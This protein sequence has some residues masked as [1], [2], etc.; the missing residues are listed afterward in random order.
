[1]VLVLAAG[2]AG[3]CGCHCAHP[4]AISGSEQTVKKD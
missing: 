3:V 4:A 1:M 2:F